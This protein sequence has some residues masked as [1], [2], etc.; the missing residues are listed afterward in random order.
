MIMT[1]NASV[2]KK[3]YSFSHYNIETEIENNKKYISNVTPEIYKTGDPVNKWWTFEFIDSISK[4]INFD[5]INVIFDIGSRDCYQSWEFRTWF[6][7]S[8][9]Y[10]F[11]PNPEQSNLCSLI[12]QQNNINLITKAVGNENKKIS[13]NVYDTVGCSSLLKTNSSNPR[14]NTWSFK[15]NYEVDMIRLDD[16]CNQNDVKVVD[17]LWVDVQGYEENVFR[18]CENMLDNVKAIFT[19]VGDDVNDEDK[20]YVNGATFKELDLFLKSKNFELLEIINI[21]TDEKSYEM[22]LIYI[23]KKFKI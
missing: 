18:G 5:D 4:Y 23:N 13:F 19:E 20:L 3:Y 17:L 1:E 14:S 7:N 15:T 16:W 2:Q 6:P 12:A 8:E 21:P 9:I 11:E 22:D 10:A